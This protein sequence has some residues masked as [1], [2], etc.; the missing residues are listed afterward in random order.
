MMNQIR[1]GKPRVL[2]IAPSTRGFGFAVL[3]TEATLVDW[4]VKSVAG[5]KNGRS[6]VK[7]KEL[8]GHYEPGVLVLPDTSR[9][10]SLRAARIRS[11]CQQIKTMGAAHMV[12]V[13]FLSRERVRRAFFADG[14]GTKHAMA[15]IIAKRFPEELGTRLP[16]KRR[17]WM[18][19]DYR[20]D[21][22]D[23]VALALASRL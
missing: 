3:E 19:E 11:L 23:A 15:E 2:A 22:F 10:D 16:P 18:S 21:I 20:M 12:R 17:P 8:I 9:K 7:V 14:R 6:L 13:V 5:D 1:Q 4:G